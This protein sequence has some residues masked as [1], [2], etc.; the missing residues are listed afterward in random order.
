MRLAI[1]LMTTMILAAPGA[2]EEFR[3]WQAQCDDLDACEAHI[4][5]DADTS[6][7]ILPDYRLALRKRAYDEQW[8]ISLTTNAALPAQDADITVTIDG[9][10]QVFTAPN[11]VGAFGRLNAFHFVGPRAQDLLD[12]L[13]PGREVTFSF[14]DTTGVTREVNL[15]L[16]GLSASI[17]WMEEQQGNVGAAR[18]AGA[19][20]SRLDQ[21]STR[22][23]APVP[24]DL[25][26]RN[27]EHNEC[28]DPESLVHGDEVQSY[29]LSAIHTL[30]LLPC[31]AGAYNL[32]YTAYVADGNG[33]GQIYFATYSDSMGWGG[34]AV[35]VN[36]SFDETTG[37]LSTFAKG[38]G[39]GD[40]G[41]VGRWQWDEYA[42]KMLIMRARTA[43]TGEGGPDTFPVVYAAPDIGMPTVE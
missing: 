35:L 36:P 13:I 41:T 42:F 38:R 22:E 43:C 26:A 28:G 15:S 8:K 4:A 21:V 33:A 10:T 39:V 29:R 12:R 9:S 17:L 19:P 24:D 16:S 18:L 27:A 37:L 34:Q 11:D 14:R 30:Y 25:V 31:W 40:C 3:D 7:S 2:A 1:A 32:G 20:P 6:D 23:P 5:V